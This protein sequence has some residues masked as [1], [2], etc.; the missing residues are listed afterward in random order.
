MSV[1]GLIGLTDHCSQ[2]EDFTSQCAL[3][4]AAGARLQPLCRGSPSLQLATGLQAI[5]LYPYHPGLGAPTL[6][7]GFPVRPFSDMLWSRVR[8]PL[9][10]SRLTSQV[11]PQPVVRFVQSFMPPYGA[12]HY[13][14]PLPLIPSIRPTGFRLTSTPS[15]Y[16]DWSKLSELP[17]F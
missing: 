2:Q 1:R 12:P 10:V 11:H 8:F 17:G 3:D 7:S 6:V 4:A 16:G 15:A 5:S 9:S 13:R 14:N